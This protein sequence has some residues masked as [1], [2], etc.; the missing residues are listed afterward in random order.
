[1][2]PQ[3]LRTKSTFSRQ[4]EEPTAQLF[5]QFHEP[6]YGADFRSID[7]AVDGF[8]LLAERFHSLFADD[9]FGQDQAHDVVVAHA[10]SGLE[11][12]LPI[13]DAVTLAEYLEC[14]DVCLGIVYQYA[15]HIEQDSPYHFVVF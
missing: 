2:I 6:P 9:F 12:V 3:L 11:L 10:E 5:E 1:M 13:F 4:P 7:F 15:V 8:F 14:L